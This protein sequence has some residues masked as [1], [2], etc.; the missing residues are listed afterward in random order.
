VRDEAATTTAIFQETL[1]PMNMKSAPTWAFGALCTL[2]VLSSGAG[3][4]QVRQLSV[5]GR[6]E[7]GEWELRTR[8]DA[9]AP[10]RLCLRDGRRLIQLRHAGQKCSRMVVEDTPE[11]MTVQ[12]TCPGRGYGRTQIRLESQSLVQID[13]QGIAEGLPFAFAAEARRLGSC[14]R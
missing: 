2:A 10:Q 5:L 3:W 7:A 11:Q 9:E 1:S 14:R 12:Y 4:A 13:S 6:L 8:D